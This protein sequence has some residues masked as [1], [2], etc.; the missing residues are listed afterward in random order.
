MVF[1]MIYPLS[2]WL[3]APT[4]PCHNMKI[5]CRDQGLFKPELG[6]KVFRDCFKMIINTGMLGDIKVPEDEIVKCR[7]HILRREQRDTKSDP[8]E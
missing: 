7:E 6:R 5:L 8:E 1:A 2:L 3:E 4:P